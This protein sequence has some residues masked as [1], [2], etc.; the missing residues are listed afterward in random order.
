MAR[1]FTARSPEALPPLHSGLDLITCTMHLI[2]TNYLIPAPQKGDES[3]LT[4][5]LMSFLPAERDRLHL[6]TLR[7]NFLMAPCTCDFVAQPR[8]ALPSMLANAPGAFATVAIVLPPD[9][10]KSLHVVQ[11]A[12]RTVRSSHHLLTLFVGV[13]AN[14][15]AW[16]ALEGLDGWVRCAQGAEPRTAVQV[17]TLL[18][19][20]MSPET[21]NC[22]DD[23][24][25][26]HALGSSSKPS[27]LSQ[28]LWLNE[29]E[30]LLWL[31][32]GDESTVAHAAVS[33]VFPLTS[34]P[35][36]RDCGKIYRSIRTSA[37]PSSA[38]YISACTNFLKPD[39]VSGA[40]P[41]LVLSRH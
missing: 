41:V 39:L 24:D 13:C 8:T 23:A 37:P 31:E 10:A 34:H 18:A 14:P 36:L 22:I 5:F 25:V 35:T 38:V 11:A 28:A 21:L 26:A 2:P 40:Y 29:R 15:A 32:A 1:Y 27:H 6:R 33:V 30:E 9:P 12:L 20:L 16:S 19:T 7:Q 17:F 3:I 4:A